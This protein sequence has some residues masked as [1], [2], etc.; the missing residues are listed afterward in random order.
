MLSTCPY[1]EDVP[2]PRGLSLTKSFLYN[3]MLDLSLEMTLAQFSARNF[4][5]CTC[6]N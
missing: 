6:G 3:W 4:P 2:R 1:V 5:C